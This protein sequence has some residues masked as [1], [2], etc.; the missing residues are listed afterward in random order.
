MGNNPSPDVSKKPVH[1]ISW[2][3][4]IRFCNVFS[5]NLGLEQVYATQN[6][7]VEWNRN[8]NGFR[9]PTEEWGSG[10]TNT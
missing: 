9:L 8:A 2:W 1:Q 4:A 3:E 7:V 5:E 10:C 6:G